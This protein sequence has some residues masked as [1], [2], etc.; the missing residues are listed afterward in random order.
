MKC[1]TALIRSVW[2]SAL[3]TLVISGV[4][5]AATGVSGEE[6][7]PKSKVQPAQAV[8]LEGVPNLY[9]VSDGL[10][11]SAQPTKEGMANLSRLGIKTIL[12]LRS[13]H[14]DHSKISGTGLAYE[15]ISMK[16]QHAE[17]EDVLRFIKLVT[18]PKRT[19]V[20]V[21]CKHGADR[22]GLTVA[23]YRIVVQGWTKEE[24]IHEMTKGGF[25]FHKIFDGL[26]EFV[27]ELDVEKLKKDAG[28]TV[29]S[30]KNEKK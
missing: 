8:E 30:P 6:K 24:A 17:Y 26:P 29:T 25:G 1:R 2:M 3:S 15:H 23:V 18:D 27:Q 14:S 7:T 10:Y 19:P 4:L 5:L 13:Y 16:A 21:H 28:L 12:N 22:T 20:L 9:K 11:R